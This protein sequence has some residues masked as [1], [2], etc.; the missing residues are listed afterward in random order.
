[1]IRKT[2]FLLALTAATLLLLTL[3]CSSA[4]SPSP[5]E[6][7]DRG[8]PAPT[9]I[10][11]QARQSA[12]DFAQA[13]QQ[14]EQQWNQI[15]ADFDEWQAG[16]TSCAPAA[17]D[18][19]LR[20]FNSDFATVTRQAANLPR[21]SQTRAL[22][23]ELIAA[24][25]EE[26][27]ALRR[28]RDR[29]TPGD[30]ALFEAVEEA[31]VV[32]LSA[33]TE[34][35]DGIG[36][37]LDPD[38]SETEELLADFD[39]ALQDLA[40]Q[41]DDVHAAYSELREKEDSLSPAEIAGELETILDQLAAVSDAIDNLPSASFNKS[42]IRSL[43]RAARE[44]K[45][46]FTDLHEQFSAGLDDNSNGAPPPPL[47]FPPIST[48]SNGNGA[49]DEKDSDVGE[50]PQEPPAVPSDAPDVD[51]DVADAPVNNSKTVLADAR[52]Q[53]DKWV[54]NP[55]AI[56]T[57]SPEEQADALE[58]QTKFDSLTRS[59]DAFHDSYD[60]WRLTNGGCDQA[61]VTSELS[62]FAARLSGLSTQ[63]GALPHAAFLQPLSDS[64]LEAAQREEEAMRAL[65][66]S[67]QPFDA[68]AY[69]GVESARAD[70]AQV[71][72]QV[73]VALQ[74]LQTRFATPAG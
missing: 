8:Q 70:A 51:F 5:V 67:W 10:S 3:A 45:A 73:Q 42:L 54:D 14:I 38:S 29:W 16:L 31:R 34:T 26:Q 64:L 74:E 18:E 59:W 55:S 11:P 61:D 71:R 47:D 65:N 15:H 22:A 69:R 33:R 60:Q 36:D 1:M 23:D 72:R 66:R 27:A 41:W 44:E 62:G 7:P 20:E 58:F 50:P 53:V 13:H 9:P 63:V 49:G 12:A 37:I 32:S 17:A 39:E 24:A 6:L 2:G 46:G 35:A 40:D 30:D 48:Q 21:T 4:A 57:V 28:L 68:N 43:S 25:Q 56:E 19:A 52:Q